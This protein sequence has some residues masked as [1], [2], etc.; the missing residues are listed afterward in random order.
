ML[1]KIIKVICYILFWMWQVSNWIDIFETWPFFNQVTNP[2]II[3]ILSLI[4]AVISSYS[5][6]SF[7]K[8]V[9]EID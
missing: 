8:W 9:W 4:L 1:R 5:L 7:I 6:I 3:S 2:T